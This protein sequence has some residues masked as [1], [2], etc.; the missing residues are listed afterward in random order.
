MNRPE[1]QNLEA[2]PAGKGFWALIVTQFQGA[3]S[4]NTLKYLVIFMIIG[5]NLP[6][7]RRQLMMGVIGALFTLPFI[8][9]S[10]AGGYF[11]DHHSKRNVTVA[12]K[13]FE[14]L[15][16]IFATFALGFNIMNLILTALFLMGVHSAIFGPSKYGLLPELL[17]ERKLS[18]GNG[19]LEFGTFVA[20]ILGT[21]A[22]GLLC[23]CF[24]GRQQWSGVILIGLA[25]I[26]FFT[27][28]GIPHV[29]PAGSVKKFEKFFII[30]LWEQIKD[31][32]KDRILWL[33][34]IGYIYFWFI[35]VVLQ[36]NVFS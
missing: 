6:Q 3:F 35:G 22:G 15:V 1:T 19:V 10:M 9:F 12:I 14:I 29:P 8:I 25:V 17:P 2:E 31:I 30:E 36:Q 4:D 18:W 32:R 33:A 27:S 28:L 24:A 23:K 20:I 7:G 11:A 21:L 16:M 13:I 34:T 26:G 5:M